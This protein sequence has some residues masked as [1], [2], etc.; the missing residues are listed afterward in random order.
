MDLKEPQ[1]DLELLSGF[2]DYLIN[3]DEELV[4]IIK[5]VK[6]DNKF[7][8]KCF[9]ALYKCVKSTVAE[10]AV[11]ERDKI[12]SEDRSAGAANSTYTVQKFVCKADETSI[13]DKNVAYSRLEAITL[14]ITDK[15]IE[16]LISLFATGTKLFVIVKNQNDYSRFVK[17]HICALNN[18]GI[19]ENARRYSM[20]AFQ[21]MAIDN[22][23][24]EAV[25][26]NAYSRFNIDVVFNGDLQESFSITNGV[27]I[28]SHT[29]EVL[30]TLEGFN[31]EQYDIEHTVEDVHIKIEAGAGTGKTFSM[32][33]RVAHLAWKKNYTPQKL[34]NSIAMIT[35][36]NDAADN[37]QKRLKAHFENYLLL[38]KRPEFI[39]A[40]LAVDQMQIS[41]IHK[42]AKN[43]LVLHGARLGY[44]NGLDIDSS[45]YYLREKIVRNNINRVL[46]TMGNPHLGLPHYEIEKL[47]ISIIDGIYKKGVDP[48]KLTD[49]NFG[50]GTPRDVHN[51]ICATV[52][53]AAIDHRDYC[54]DK[55]KV[56]L[57][58]LMVELK[59]MA[60]GG[61]LLP[62]EYLFIDEFQDTDDGQI[63]AVS[64]ICEKNE[65]M[66]LFVVG[67]IKQ[68]I[69]RFRGAQSTAFDL[70][71]EKLKS[72]S[73]DKL[74][75][76]KKL[77]KNYRSDNRLLEKYHLIF[78]RWS[79]KRT[80][81][82]GLPYYENDMLKSDIAADANAEVN[83]I[84]EFV[85][86]AVAELNRVISEKPI[87]TG[88]IAL[89]VR[90]NRQVDEVNK[91]LKSQGINNVIVD[92]GGKLYNS[93]AGIDLLKLL[94]AL[95]NWQDVQYLFAF[96]E[97]N[98]FQRG[99]ISYRNLR[100]IN[101]QHD[102]LRNYFCELINAQFNNFPR[103][104]PDEGD[105]WVDIHMRLSN[106]SV[107]SVVTDIVEHCKP[108][109]R[110]NE[111]YRDDIEVI[112]EKLLKSSQYPTILELHQ[113]LSV[114]VVTRQDEETRSVLGASDKPEL[115]VYC[116]T[117]H[118]AKGLEFDW[119]ILPKANVK[120]N[121]TTN[122]VLVKDDNSVAYS[123]EINHM[124]VRNYNYDDEARELEK[125]SQLN[126]EYRVFYVALTRAKFGLSYSRGNGE[127]IWSEWIRQ[128]LNF[129]GYN[130]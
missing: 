36:T 73:R 70:L 56:A 68:C 121:S 19:S 28:S 82:K 59:N 71:L 113:N 9:E 37:M 94:G 55:S 12:C 124:D 10:Y 118:K 17:A 102:R 58:R 26:Q 78:S 95:L 64:R 42:F 105:V 49:V 39:D 27:D 129:G 60:I 104:N 6:F 51:V 125:R 119:V 61:L 31:Y 116:M 67:D 86:D 92:R 52:P 79:A 114:K 48:C 100:E 15:E 44:S 63:E 103:F 46:E 91:A 38:T 50:P 109:Q 7:K 111:Q 85:G 2:T 120:L 99:I 77:T 80:N 115:K 112:I 16:S 53:S 22:I 23:V 90:T 3:A 5:E 40:I 84:E 11:E 34:A 83:A 25:K 45:D 96:L 106:E 57:R 127:Y 32:V 98:F 66:K 30:K 20:S 75:S 93:L 122:G 126:E 107:L 33:N 128:G 101:R 14:S 81:G 76:N 69:Y 35:F 62:Y 123:Y 29:N 54:Q 4:K 110:C 74:I 88:S 87:K 21:N 13:F 1:E 41:T 43:L 8:R 130:G 72:Y 97:S 47:I 18:K 117:V 89:L 108:W 65:Q 24:N